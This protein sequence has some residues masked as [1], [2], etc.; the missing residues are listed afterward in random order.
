M[1]EWVKFHRQICSGEKKGIPRALRFVYLEIALEAYR[2]HGIVRLPA[3]MK[4]LDAIH[5]R[6]GGNRREISA[7]IGMFSTGPD[8]SWV[9]QESGEVRTIEV[10]NWEHWNTRDWSAERTRVYRNR[11]K[12]GEDRDKLAISVSDEANKNDHLALPVTVTTQ[13]RSEESRSEESRREERESAERERRVG[14]LPQT[15]PAPPGPPG[16]TPPSSRAS[17][18]TLEGIIP[19]PQP[20]PSP[21]PRKPPQKPAKQSNG[22]PEQEPSGYPAVVAA[23]FESFERAR[24]DK[25]VF[26]PREG[27][28]VRELLV[29]AGQDRAIERIRAAYAEEFWRSKITIIEIA[30]NPDK[31]CGAP[32]PAPRESNLPDITESR[33]PY[34]RPAK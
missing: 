10:K 19:P 14:A 4:L 13:D 2:E 33:R 27:K 18:T 9:I 7:A 11:K 8:P 21:K 25:P 30:A 29:K 5:D 32:K 15:P 22:K 1:Q 24:G 17:Q 26:G 28:A 34:A 20:T 12:V 31:Y 16:L 6:I 3:R 23:Y